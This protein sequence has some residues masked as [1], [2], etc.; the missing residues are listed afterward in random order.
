MDIKDIKIAHKN[1]RIMGKEAK[2]ALS[3]SLSQFND[4]SGITINK[5]TGNVVSGNHRWAELNKVYGKENLSLS[6]L[7]GEYNTLDCK[8]KFT[9]FIVRLVDWEE[10]KELAANITANSNLV[11]G[12]FT[13][14]LQT[15]LEGVSKELDT[16]IFE[17]LRLD[18]LQVDLDDIDDIEWDDKVEA[19][20]REKNTLLEDSKE[21]EASELKDII[22]SIKV[23]VPSELKDV[24]K[25][26]IREALA[27][28]DYFDDIDIL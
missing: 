1:P 15:I 28:K 14:E 4:I 9:G 26:D 3:K 18:E 22:T 16:D 24:V 25:K 2:L 12:E 5:R 21:K 20:A 17:G 6:L 7:Q 11:Q 8:N 13:S 27:K 19:S 23:A 10:S